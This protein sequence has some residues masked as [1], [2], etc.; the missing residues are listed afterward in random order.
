MM[1]LRAEAERQ[2]MEINL[3]DLAAEAS[4]AQNATL[5]IG[6]YSP[7]M[8]VIGTLPM[9]FYDFEAPGIQAITGAGHANPSV[10]ERAL[11]LRQ[12]AITAATQS[13]MENRIARAGHTRPQRVPLDELQPGT[14]EVEFHREDADGFGW[15]GPALLLKLN[16]NGSAIVEYQGRPYLIPLRN[17]RLF[18]GV[19]Y[20]DMD[21]PK[22][23]EAVKGQELESWI[24]LRR[25]M[26]SVEACVPFKI[27][28]FGHLRNRRGKWT[29]LPKHMGEEQLTAI[30]ADIVTAA[31]FLTAKTCHGIR[32]GVGLKKM[33][34]PEGSTG[35]LVAWK[36]KTVRM[37]IVDNPHGTDMGTHGLRLGSHEE[38]C[39]LYFYSYTENFVEPPFETWVPKG[40]P[41]EES[42]VMPIPSN[43]PAGTLTS[44]TKRDGPETRTVTLG[45]E[46]K[47]Q[48]I[49][50]ME[51][52][53]EY[54]PE[55]YWNMHKHEWM[56]QLPA[57]DVVTSEEAFRY[58]YAASDN[59]QL[60]YMNSPGW[61]ADLQTGS[62]FRVDS[63]T[64]SIEED[65]LPGIWPQVE[66]ADHKEIGQFVAEQAFKP[67]RR[68]DLP[69][70]CAI[71][72]GIWV[73]K[74]K[75]TAEKNRIVK[76]RMCVRGCHDPWKNELNNRDDVESW[77]IAGAFLKGLTYEA[78]WKC[79]RKLGLHT[80]ERLIAIVPPRNVWR[81]LRKL[82]KEFDIPEDQRDEFVLRCLKPVYGLS[83]APLA[84]QL[85]LHQ[86]L[87][88][89]GGIQSL[90]D[91]C[92][93]F[94]PSTRPGTWPKAS[95]TTHVDDLAARG[96]R[97]WLDWAYAKMLEKF[98]K[99]T[100]Q[101]LPFMHCGCRYSRLPDG[102][103]V[104]QSDYV[105]M[106]QP[107]SIAADD[108]DERDL[109][110]HETTALRSVIGGLMWTSLTRPDV[111]AELSTLQSIMNKA[112]V[113]HLRSANALTERAKQDVE[114]AVYY[115]ALPSKAYRIVCVHDAS[116]AT[117]T[118]NYAQ[119]GV[120]V[121]LVADTV[122]FAQ[123]HITASDEFARHRLS[124]RA[125]LLHMQSNKAKRVSYS[126]SHGETLAAINGLEC[127]T[128]VSA[129]LAEI[130]MGR[131][132]PTIQQLLAVQ[133]RGCPHFP[134]D[135][136]TDCR[137]FF[138]LTTGARTLPQDKSQRL[139]ILAHREARAS[140]RIRWTILTPTECMTADALTKVMQSPCLMKWLS[141][142][143]V[144]F[145]NCGHPLE[146]K[147]LPD[148]LRAMALLISTKTT[149]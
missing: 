49:N 24:A 127:S 126:T 51:P 137:D 14:S 72:D 33:F 30:L 41:M 58:G 68:K 78:L 140:G 26:Q 144:E 116:A 136:H 87:R 130:T 142:G 54:M 107:V 12:M 108:K 21:S 23:D 40:A 48:R 73:R 143:V 2:G 5:N 95:L 34:T 132:K 94:W 97:T 77:D 113:T 121:F 88:D 118:K 20:N 147:R 91:E 32:V 69:A 106:H 122:N 1:K 146:L 134:T 13:I 36:R 59:H 71:I 98:G 123:E 44:G 76:S 60:F 110:P 39:Y 70:N 115:R 10:Y 45:P 145:W 4:F 129:R 9:P 109:L 75:K 15:R 43:D 99:L 25:L 18:R 37:S 105:K 57:D 96:K 82:S 22:S 101:R 93:W 19:Y 38:M 92:F 35:T 79:L 53:S 112:K 29:R 141:T 83:E 124:G 31:Q 86:F 120:L 67:S 6:G 125:Q 119:E 16:E 27:E 84:W 135:V 133:E 3:A 66:E 139:Y 17:L 56:T 102:Y 74:W 42:P 50:H 64:D 131:T 138:E 89:L 80:V 46:S 104:D 7:H 28:T 117:S 114:A 103:K 47:K 52:M 128:L 62:V 148:L 61:H 81:H 149:W 65:D 85:F 90:F 111:L 55:V 100:R 8:M 11:R 63:T